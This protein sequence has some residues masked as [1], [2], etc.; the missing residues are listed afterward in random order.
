MTQQTTTFAIGRFRLALAIDRAGRVVEAW[1]P[2]P[3]I[4]LNPEELKMYHRAK[5]GY[6]APVL[7]DAIPRGTKTRRN[8][9]GKLVARAEASE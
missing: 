6:A 4:R 8:V 7:L 3:P 5:A 2:K 1:S 9:S